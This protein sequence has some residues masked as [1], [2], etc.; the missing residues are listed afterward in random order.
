MYAEGGEFTKSIDETDE[1]G[2][3]AF[4]NEVIQIYCE[5]NNANIKIGQKKAVIVGKPPVRNAI[6][7]SQSC[8]RRLDKLGKNY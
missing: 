1:E 3:A 5:S 8:W 7:K 2:T 4:P 6:L